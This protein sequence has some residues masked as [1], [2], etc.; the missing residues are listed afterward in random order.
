M[1]KPYDLLYYM[2]DMLMYSLINMRN[3][4]ISAKLKIY[5]HFL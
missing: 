4:A 5:F 1:Q 3:V 2:N